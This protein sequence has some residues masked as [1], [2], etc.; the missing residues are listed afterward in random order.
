MDKKAQEALERLSAAS[1]F[2]QPQLQRDLASLRQA[3]ERTRALDLDARAWQAVFQLRETAAKAA[4]EAEMLAR[5]LQE[6]GAAPPRSKSKRGAAPGTAEDGGQPS[7]GGVRGSSPAGESRGAA[8]A[9]R[10]PRTSDTPRAVSA[11]SLA[12]A[13]DRRARQAATVA[14]KAW[15]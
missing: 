7:A 14:P 5:A 2:W 8:P 9:R 10:K 1:Q 13:D 15:S 3:L 12:A 6:G 11:K 4:N